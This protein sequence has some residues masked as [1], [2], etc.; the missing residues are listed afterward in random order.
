MT[1]GIAAVGLPLAF[2]DKADLSWLDHL[3]STFDRTLLL[4]PG[5]D[6]PRSSHQHPLTIHERQDFLASVYGPALSEGRLVCAPMVDEPYRPGLRL[7]ACREAVDQAFGHGSEPVFVARTEAQG[8]ELARFLPG[9]APAIREF[10]G[11]RPAAS[12]FGKLE[13][14][15]KASLWFSRWRRTTAAER[16]AAEHKDCV[17]FQ[18][19]WR[20]SPFPPTFNAGDAIVICGDEILLIER[21][22]WPFKGLLALPGGFL[23]RWETL[24]DAALRE[25]AEEVRVKREDLEKLLRGSRTLDYPWR[26]PR[27]RFISQA[28]LFILKEKPVGLKAGS[29]AKGFRW[30]KWAELS[31][32]DLAFD[33]WHAIRELLE[34]VALQTG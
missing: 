8:D 4:L 15:E 16:M 34:A 20:G 2:W 22:N 5:S 10:G 14:P 19:T 18:R 7:A 6:R 13:L 27:G 30:E 12:L 9:V 11:A 33:H 23:E 32:Q 28:Y 31:P 1:A 17:A 29:D 21:D 25:A 26:D 3:L 24:F